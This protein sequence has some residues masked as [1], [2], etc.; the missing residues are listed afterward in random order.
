MAEKKY[1]DDRNCNLSDAFLKPIRE[2][3]N[4]WAQSFEAFPD[5][6][7]GDNIEVSE[8]IERIMYRLTLKTESET[9]SVKTRTVPYKGEKLD[10][11]SIYKLADVNPWDYQL[12]LPDGFK[13]ENNSY[14]VPGSAEVDTCHSCSGYGKTSCRS[15]A[16]K[17]KVTCSSC[18]GYGSV[19]CGTCGGRGRVDTE[20]KCTSCSGRGYVIVQE[21][22]M[23]YPTHKYSEGRMAYVDKKKSC[24]N[25]NG[26]G[27]RKS[28]KS[29]PT[30][31]SSGKVPCKTCGQS[32]YV[33][34][35]NCGGRGEVT[36]A[37]CEGYKK[38]K[39]YFAIEQEDKFATKHRYYVNMEEDEFN[40]L[41]KYQVQRDFKTVDCF[42]SKDGALKLDLSEIK[43]E[44]S[45]SMKNILKGTEGT[46]AQRTMFQEL[47]IEKTS[48]W[49]V[50]CNYSGRDYTLYLTQSGRVSALQSPVT[51]YA[52]GL[53]PLLENQINRRQLYKAAETSKKLI[54]MSQDEAPFRALYNGISNKMRADYR[55]GAFFA[56]MLAIATAYP[57]N[58]WY[59]GSV[60]FMAPWCAM[61]HYGNDMFI[62]AVP[63]VYTVLAGIFPVVMACRSKKIYLRCR[64]FFG[65]FISG[66]AIAILNYIAGTLILAVL[67]CLLLPV[68]WN[69]LI[70]IWMLIEA[71]FF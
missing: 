56:V 33:T 1:T 44:V 61:S 51:N 9:R 13:N 21:M 7:L 22:E 49:E 57:L 39:S 4:H 36:C 16:G 5:K 24:S 55:F 35:S 28:T 48:V 67:H 15:C 19:N 45:Q 11:K 10:P 34:C 41:L 52:Q 18:R 64:T 29:C 62:K 42:S 6:N 58:Q 37:S 63:Y 46:S 26:H 27:Y 40:N 25:C 12:E 23:I 69:V 70:S 38:L 31:G 43:H 65:R 32:G 8:V 60:S 54:N 53:M 2:C 68:L 66:F 20:I 3:I 59:Y 71:I 50:N 30:C 47:R 14:V 17:G